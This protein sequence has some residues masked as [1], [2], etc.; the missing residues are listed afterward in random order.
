MGVCLLVVCLMTA[1]LQRCRTAAGLHSAGLRVKVGY[2]GNRSHLLNNM[3]CVCSHVLFSVRFRTLE[4][5]SI[6]FQWY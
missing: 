5:I 1:A 2:S 4:G 6:V 3:W